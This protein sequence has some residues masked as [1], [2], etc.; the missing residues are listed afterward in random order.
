MSNF[1][2]VPVIDVHSENLREVWPSMILAL[3]N[4]TFVGLD[5]EL[6]GL[7][8]RKKLGAKSVEDRY[9]NIC[10]TAK[11]RSILSLGVSCFQQMSA[12]SNT[13]QS[14]SNCL[15]SSQSGSRYI[16][17]TFNIMLLCEEE[18]MVEPQSLR[19]L[20]Q[21]GFDFN[22]QYEKGVPYYRGPDKKEDNNIQSVRHLFSELVAME[23]PIILHNG[24]VDLIFMYENLYTSLP[25]S[26][27]MFLADLCDM[28]PNGIIDTKYITDF[29][30]LMQA[31]YLE[32]VFRKCQK[33]NES[34]A[35][36]CTLHFPHY[37]ASYPH[38]TYRNCNI[39]P[40]FDIDQNPDA[41]KM[42]LCG[43]YS[44]HGW[45]PKEKFC[46]KSHDIDLI[47]DVD[48]FME[49]R[50]GR[51]RKRRREN[52]EAKET[53]DELSENENV[54]KG[55][56]S[57]VLDAG[58]VTVENGDSDDGLKSKL[59][60]EEILQTLKRQVTEEETHANGGHRAGYDAF[61]TGFIYAVYRASGGKWIDKT[62]EWRNKLYLGGKDYPLSVSKSSFSKHS[63]QHLEK[64]GTIRKTEVQK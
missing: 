1:G 47:I 36:K 3:S 19:F 43:S 63:K 24:L 41:Y 35:E 22:K 21:H 18:F 8:H 50:K 49:K 9:K 26:S 30:H 60:T 51:K 53:T 44:G 15:S 12:P 46:S 6:S 14:E 34:R 2:R 23:K 32:Y 29:E 37:P 57:A 62:E 10:E 27:A 42:A 52:K 64:I 5:T 39:K 20:V 54:S 11:S 31:S 56:N 55:S 4:A 48:N 40:K 16:V 38:V 45:C 58:D 28:F 7:G 17:Q 25:S 59:N 61:M 13:N 33:D